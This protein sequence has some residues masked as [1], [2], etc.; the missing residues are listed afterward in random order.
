MPVNLLQPKLGSS[1]GF[2]RKGGAKRSLR[3]LLRPRTMFLIGVGIPTLV[4]LI[5]YGFVA[6]DRYV[7][8]ASFVVRGI[9]SSRT[10]GLEMFF[11]TFGLARTQDD[12]NVVQNYL[13]SRDAVRALEK[14][15]P[16]RS[17]FSP[18]RADIISKFTRFWAGE[19]FEDL[20]DYYLDRVSVTQQP[21]KGISVLRVQAF[22]PAQAK[23]I[24]EVL[25]KLGEAKVNEMNE[26]AHGDAI[27]SAERD[28][29]GAETILKNAQQ[30]LADFRNAEY[31]ID[32][33]A[34]A[35]SVL[36]TITTLSTALAN[37]RAQ[38]A[39]SSKNAPANPAASALETQSA[40]YSAGIEAER[41]KLAGSAAALASKLATYDRL[42]LERTMAEKR[43]AA[44]ISSLGSARQEARRQ[45]IY[46]E[47]ITEPNLPDK[48]TEPRRL[49]MIATFLV[50]SFA[51][52]A[53]GWLLV[54]GSKEHVSE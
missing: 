1:Q 22:E 13:L 38:I 27:G 52:T 48:S 29:D 4:A 47:E 6:T 32:P 35:Q 2:R 24:A 3:E 51:L 34:N 26:R 20:Y 44:A 33:G 8:E 49:R 16:L 39:Q 11:R 14:Q 42:I 50:F 15:V 19:S 45:Q 30:A 17:Y 41:A 40:A 43:L 54:T 12:T 37:T 31:L 53:V 23:A 28:V 25:L 7:S 21:S 46:I 36:Q 10:S 18:A 9:S 5:Y